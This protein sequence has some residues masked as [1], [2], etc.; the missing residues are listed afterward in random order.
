MLKIVFLVPERDFDAP[1]QD[2]M[3]KAFIIEGSQYT[4]WYTTIRSNL[5]LTRHV[6]VVF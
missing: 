3:Y 4:L 2:L 6:Y 1:A 5:S